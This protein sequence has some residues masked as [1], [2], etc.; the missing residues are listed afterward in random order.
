[1]NEKVALQI[2]EA[3]TLGP[4]AFTELTETLAAPKNEVECVLNQLLRLGF[5]G[6][7][8]GSAPVVR[9]HWIQTMKGEAG[10][11]QNL[12]SATVGI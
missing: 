12:G 7:S 4:L 11:I 2:S 5:L 6:I 3:L 10:L 9:F 8:L 1:L